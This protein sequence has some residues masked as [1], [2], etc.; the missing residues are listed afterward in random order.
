MRVEKAGI[1]CGILLC[2]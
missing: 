1:L 2:S